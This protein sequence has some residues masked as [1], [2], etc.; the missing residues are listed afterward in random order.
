M[1]DRITPATTEADIARLAE[2]T[3]YHDPGL[4]VHEPFGQW[5]IEDKF[6]A[7]RPAWDQV[8]V[9]MVR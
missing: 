8:G 1:V 5:V 2:L 9:Q 4:V 6:A 7:G 3:G